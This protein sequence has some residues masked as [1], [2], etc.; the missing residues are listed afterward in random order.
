MS[1]KVTSTEST[2]KVESVDRDYQGD[3]TT[4]LEVTPTGVKVNGASVGSAGSV[5]TSKLATKAVTKAKALVFFSTEITGTGSA[6]N[7]AH[8][9]G[10][11]PAGVLVAPTDLTPATV[12]Q[13][14][15]V[16]GTH[17]TTN[18]V[19]TITT[20]KKAKIFAWG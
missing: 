12:G 15:C 7:V 8:G 1:I 16:E 11:A 9:L 6:Q 17:T 20:G 10:V 14:S 4:V 2:F 18:V 3:A 5:T 19:V 13:Y